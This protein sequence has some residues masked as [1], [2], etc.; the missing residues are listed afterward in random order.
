[1][2]LKNVPT[3]LLFITI[4]IL[5]LAGRADGQPVSVALNSGLGTKA[6]N[7]HLYYYRT[8][9]KEN[10]KAISKM[11]G[12]PAFKP[13]F[14]EKAI[15]AGVTSDYYWLAFSIKGN[16]SKHQTYYFQLH[17]PWLNMAAI[18]HK[19]D[20]GFVLV[21]KAGM[22]L[23]FNERPYKYYDIVFP[24]QI[25]A[26]KE[27]SYL[28]LIDNV[29]SSLNLLP[30]LT[31]SDS[32]LAREKR[33]Y[34]FF[35]MLTG[36]MLFSI[37]INLFLYLSLREKIHLYYSV[38][39]LSMLYWIYCNVALDFQY[40]YPNNPFLATVSEYL[41]VGAGFVT[42][43]N[44]IV[45]FL[46]ISRK[47]SRFKIYVDILKYLFIIL[48]PLS[49]LVYGPL[50]D[51]RW[52]KALYAS[53][54]VI[55]AL[56]TSVLFFLMAIE[57]I[58]QKKTFAWFFLFSTCY[59]GVAIIKYCIYLLGGSL[60]SSVQEIPSDAQIGL[61]I[62]AIIIFM[63]II[64]RYNLYKNEKEALLIKLNGQQKE[65]VQQVISAQEEERKRIAQDIHDD[66]GSTLS[67]LLLHITNL[68][69][70]AFPL[71]ITDNVHYQKSVSIV[72]RAIRDLRSIAHNLLPKDFTELG[73]FH[74]LKNR[75]DEL[76]LMGN[77]RFTLITEGRDDD[78]EN[79][80]AITVYRI[81]N[82][83]INN[84]LKHSMASRATIQLL[85]T[86]NEIIIMIDDDG[87][88]I[89][90]GNH[91]HGIGMKNLLS[92]AA[93]LQGRV[94]ID[95]NSEGTSIIIEIPFKES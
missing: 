85:L 35:G 2:P 23:N 41:A 37:I 30:T 56:T 4:Y 12:T 72:Q 74:I 46:E 20:T 7:K 51:L 70:K 66:V 10:V 44:L 52:L 47:N 78:I 18:Y 86:G 90:Q 55:S 34:I 17:Q 32:F 89:P 91:R 95:D 33:E 38:Y 19:T 16:G 64:Y 81:I 88:G 80:F 62:E 48:S 79:V 53:T 39:V 40:L 45:S 77:I 73:I 82:E 3:K 27:A 49:L 43:T 92:R 5:L 36:V 50:N 22:K 26:Q 13:V 67:T 58:I 84:T 31:D 83:L 63:G 54:I 94:N 93:F 25:S 14:P 42:M 28:V 65:I 8:P 75:I 76:N 24:L 61:A 60:N 21:G 6:F 11:I 29:G 68:P 57:K 9:N 69:Q 15:N 71:D 1:M 59:I 87:I